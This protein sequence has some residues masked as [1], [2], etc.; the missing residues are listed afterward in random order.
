ML[1][2][3]KMTLEMSIFLMLDPGFQTDIINVFISKLRKQLCN[4]VIEN[5]SLERE[6]HAVFLWELV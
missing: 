3:I 2:V 1:N 4:V 5:N 6:K